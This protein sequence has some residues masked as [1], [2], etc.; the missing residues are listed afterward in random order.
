[1]ENYLLK[2]KGNKM[3]RKCY[4]CDKILDEKLLAMVR[5]F[6]IQDNKNV[7]QKKYYV[8]H[9]CAEIEREKK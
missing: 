2:T 7:L 3:K 4:F 1:M 6:R 9:E 5:C 8:C